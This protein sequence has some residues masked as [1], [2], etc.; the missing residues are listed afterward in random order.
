MPRKRVTANDDKA[1][2]RYMSAFIALRGHPLFAPLVYHTSITR[3]ENGGCPNDGWAVVTSNGA[4]YVHPKRH[5][6]QAEWMY[7]LGHC[8]LHLGF[9]HLVA[10]EQPRAW[11]LACDIVV[12]RLL[13]ALKFGQ[14]PAGFLAPIETVGATED[15]LYTNLCR[16]NLPAG[17]WPDLIIEAPHRGKLPNWADAF[18]RGLSAAVVSA[19]DVAG[20]VRTDVSDGSRS[21]SEA[22][23]ARRWFIN[24]YPLLG[25]LAATFTII[26]DAHMCNRLGISIAAVDI[27]G[28]EIFMNPAAGMT[29][30]ECRFVMAHEL[31]HVGLRHDVRREE[32]DPYLWNVACDYVINGWLVEMGV[33]NLPHLGALYDPS[34]KGESAEA[35]YDL[36]VTDMRR[37][38][39][40]AT[41][42]G[43]GACDI[44]ERHSPEWW[45]VGDGQDLDAFYRQCLAQGLE[46]ATSDGR[47]FF[48]AGLI[49][50]IRAL[51]QP[52]VPWDVALA[53][54]F[55]RYFAP[56][57]QRRS[58]AR[59]SR[60]Q[61]STPDIPRPRYIPNEAAQDG[62]TFG[63]VLDTSGSM[64]RELLAKALGA[65]ASYSIAH[66]VPAVR[67][68][69]C[70]AAAYDGG[71]LAPEQIAD[72]VRVKGRGG[73]VLQPGV[74]LLEHATDFPA[75]GP[76]L[77][78]TD[79]QCDRLLIRR[80]HAFILPQGRHLPFVPKG[81]VFRIV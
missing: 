18:G 49:E 51:N 56:L 65:I 62:R 54:W 59:P 50:E 69:F 75:A 74:D 16:T 73:T 45:E 26:E 19:V 41:L 70:D 11:N 33:G 61:A 71:Y 13:L 15:V 63:V 14:P 20:G 57:E 25:A 3:P 27:A 52:P 46:Y 32:R 37:F 29:E 34:L 55:D 79:G 23:A 9:G 12:D 10:K 38:R 2:E 72:R 67:V 40:L 24:S 76:L 64:D 77:I 35:V 30:A 22:Q 81:P 36:I 53:R 39:K 1:A 80:P 47:G 48:P 17:T 21:Q 4:I 8:L 6:E 66:D 44:I 28:Q 60:R 7:V 31:L 43:V 58:Y 78:I 5:A 68:V 42:R